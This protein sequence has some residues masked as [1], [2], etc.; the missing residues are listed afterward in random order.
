[1]T[2][3]ILGD[4]RTGRI[5]TRNLPVL[6]GPWSVRLGAADSLDVTVDYNDPDT[7]A[8]CLRNAATPGKAYLAVVEHDAFGQKT[9]MASGPIWTSTYD[10]DKRTLTLGAKGWGSYWDH[11][12][13][14]PLLAQTISLTSWTI[15]DPA[16]NTKTIPNPDLATKIEGLALGTIAKR[17]V[18]QAQLWTS[19]SLPYVFKADE[20]NTTRLPD[21]TFES[22]RTYI[23]ADFKPVGEAL[24]QLSE[25]EGGPEMRHTA[26]FT[27]DGTGIE[28]L[29]QTGTTTQPLISSTAVLSWDLTAPESAGYGLTIDEDASDLGSLSWATGGRSADTVLVS[30]AYDPTL[31]DLGFPL[32]EITDSSHS[33]VSVQSTL[34]SYAAANVAGGR[35]PAEVW[36]FNTKAY[37]IGSD[38]TSAG[39]SID[40]YTVGD[41]ATLHLDPYDPMTGRGDPYLAEGGTSAHRIVGLSGDSAGDEIKIQL[42][43]KVTS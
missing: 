32:M 39:H 12:I 30:R 33:S 43:Q 35:R 37:P 14:L 22:T 34:D 31:V 28:V 20:L 19:G 26:R 36:A 17:L 5:S 15:T 23:G 10:R 29:F 4:L 1:M 21:G 40:E 41:F 13:I 7:L 16:D 42:A 11:R 2:E 9:I 8:L 3:Y 18:Q 38:G 24:D 6:S 27:T 25:V